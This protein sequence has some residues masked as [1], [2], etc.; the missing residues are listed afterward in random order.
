[1]VLPRSQYSFSTPVVK[2][3]TGKNEP[4]WFNTGRP[5]YDLNKWFFRGFAI[6]NSIWSQTEFKILIPVKFNCDLQLFSFQY[7]QS[8]NLFFFAELTFSFV[9]R[10]ELALV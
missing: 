9:I 2:G 8:W 3:L 7:Y 6:A 5:A 10:I 1:M 4:D